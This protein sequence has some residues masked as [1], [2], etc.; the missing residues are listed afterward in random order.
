MTTGSL[1]SRNLR[2]GSSSR[3]NSFK[4]ESQRGFR[5]STAGF[6]KQGESSKGVGVDG[7]KV[8]LLASLRGDLI[9]SLTPKVSSLNVGSCISN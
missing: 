8:K 6:S 2:L 3:E 7:P 5:L 9:A 1:Y 4:S